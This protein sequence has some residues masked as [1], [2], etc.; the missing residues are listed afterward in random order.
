MI[1]Q[2][3]QY[4]V[5]LCTVL[6]LQSLAPRNLKPHLLLGASWFFYAQWNPSHLIILLVITTITFV[7]TRSLDNSP[8]KRGLIFALGFTINLGLLFTFKYLGF[9]QDIALSICNLLGRPLYLRPLE[10]LLPVGISFYTL[11]ALSYLT[12]VKN[13]Q[14]D[15]EKNFLSF[16]NYLAFF[17]QLIAGPIERA[18]HLL[19]QLNAQPCGNWSSIKDGSR[20]V[21]W[22]LFKKVVIAD[23]IAP[24]VQWIMIEHPAPDPATVF[25]AGILANILIY[26]DFS[27]YS[28]IAIGSA[29]MMGINIRENFKFPLFSQSMPDFW[30]RW[31]ISLHRFFIDYLYKPL[32]GGECSGL[33]KTLNIAIVFLISGLWHGAAWN[34]IIWSLYHLICVLAHLLMVY[35]WG[36]LGWRSP[37][38]WTW[39]VVKITLVHVQRGL[40]MILF[41]VPDVE[42]GLK[43]LVSVVNQPWN[44]SLSQLLPYPA[45]VQVIMLGSCLALF[46]VEAMHLHKPLSTSL[47]RWPRSL[48]WAS[49]QI[50]IFA[51]MIFGVE[52]DNPF[53]YFQF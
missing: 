27:A 30:R 1:F 23:R 16:A 15:G 34:F 46:F 4:L 28:D 13:K 47:K 3:I 33:H 2:S 9:F 35:I 25:W 14:L 18:S 20:R 42:R 22:G 37:K 45:L 53:I 29:R 50:T 19:P 41:F 49:Y 6:T 32:G 26:A 7:F 40:S 10:L 43:L 12:D 51:I 52:S 38:H 39:T 17:P 36:Y 31:H 48:R 44:S 8:H 21:L 11:Q 5:F 24:H